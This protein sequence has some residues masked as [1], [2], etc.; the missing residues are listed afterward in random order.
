[1]TY[2]APEQ[3]LTAPSPEIPMPASSFMNT[4]QA[5]AYLGMTPGAL[6]KAKHDGRV[7][8]VGHRYAT[9]RLTWAKED[10]D[11][12]LVGLAPRASVKTGRSS[13]PPA[14]TGGTHEQSIEEQGLAVE[15]E[16]E[17]LGEA[18]EA[19]RSLGEEGGRLPRQE[20]RD[21]ESDGKDARGQEGASGRGLGNRIQVA[22]GRGRT[23]KARKQLSPETEDALLRLRSFTARTQR[24][25]RTGDRSS[26]F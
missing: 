9:R 20:A 1:M 17:E 19:P 13:A 14:T 8:P 4:E 18:H 12:Y 26:S 11:R 23:R 7:L 2:E 10:L 24:A 16:V 15:Q 22:S 6:R 3:S 21:R 5:A 25:A